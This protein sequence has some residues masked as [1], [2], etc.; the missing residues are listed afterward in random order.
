MKSLFQGIFTRFNSV[1]GQTLKTLLSGR[2]YNTFAP[3]GADFPLAVV[4]LVSDVP[5]GTFTEDWENTLLQFS[6]YSLSTSAVEVCDIFD[7]LKALYDYCPLTVAGYQTLYMR[8]EFSKLLREEDESLPP[9]H[10]IIEY[11]VLMEK[12]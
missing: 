4:S 10:Y 11:R 6:V 12:A 1:D 9:W 2:L 3:Q 7:E 5:D 8:R